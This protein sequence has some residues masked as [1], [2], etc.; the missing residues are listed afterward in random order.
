MG[1]GRHDQG[2]HREPGPCS[3][4]RSLEFDIP[5]TAPTKPASAVTTKWGTPSN[6][7]TPRTPLSVVECMFES[8]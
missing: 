5:R 1:G 7:A 3:S 4:F 2:T 6:T 8:W